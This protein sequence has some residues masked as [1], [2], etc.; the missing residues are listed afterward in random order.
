MDAKTAPQGVT[1]AREFTHR[2][3]LSAP[4]LSVL[5]M[6]E[7]LKTG[8]YVFQGLKNGKPLSNLA[9]LKLLHRMGRRDLTS[10]GF[11]STFRD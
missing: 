4:A 11:R 5:K 9:M 3:P 10:H 6:I 1:I 8:D 2:V 7:K